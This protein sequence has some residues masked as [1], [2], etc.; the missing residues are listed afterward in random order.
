MSTGP[1]HSFC[2]IG[3]QGRL[4]DSSHGPIVSAPINSFYP[5]IV[6][7]FFVSGVL[8]GIMICIMTVPLTPLFGFRS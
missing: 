5:K 4:L 8:C 6:G 1:Y 3:Y 7:I 2:G